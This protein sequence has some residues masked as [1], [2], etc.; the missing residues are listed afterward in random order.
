MQQKRSQLENTAGH[1]NSNSNNGGGTNNGGSNG[2]SVAVRPNAA[3]AIIVERIENDINRMRKT[4]NL[5]I[6]VG[7]L[8]CVCWLPLNILNTVSGVYPDR[9]VLFSPLKWPL[10]T[11]FLLFQPSTLMNIS[12]ILLMIIEC[13][14]NDILLK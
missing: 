8:F 7:A 3:A 1:N 10:L 14:I 9:E 6:W 4:T 11:R 2:H 13:L 5:L 12:P